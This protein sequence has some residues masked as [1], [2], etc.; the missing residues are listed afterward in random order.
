[1]MKQTLFSFKNKLSSEYSVSTFIIKYNYII[2]LYVLVAIQCMLRLLGFA[3][4]HIYIGEYTQLNDPKS[5][6][7]DIPVI[8]FKYK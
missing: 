5:F 8:C 1:M 6:V 4:T 2:Y 7:S 3:Y